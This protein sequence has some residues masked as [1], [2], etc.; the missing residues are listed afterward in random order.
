MK[1]VLI[2]TGS[3]PVQSPHVCGSPRVCLTRSD[4]LSGVF[5]SNVEKTSV[6]RRRPNAS[7]HFNVNRRGNRKSIRR[8]VS[9]SD[10]VR[11]VSGFSGGSFRSFPAKILEE[12]DDDVG[13]GP[14]TLKRSASFS[15]VWPGFGVPL[16]QLGSSGDGFGKGSGS[17]AGRGGGGGLGGGDDSEKRKMGEYYREMLKT[18]PSDSLLLRNYGKFL[19]EVRTNTLYDLH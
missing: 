17:A 7:L 9:E 1:S 5:S 16:E 8:V 10:V 14:L 15:G 19:D 2:R 12:D 4:S 18:N 6:C 13:V 3:V 11:S